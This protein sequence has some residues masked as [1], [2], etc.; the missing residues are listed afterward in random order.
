MNHI[1]HFVPGIASSNVPVVLLH[2]SGGDEHELFPL[3][4]DVAPGSPALGVRGTVAI[5]G[6]FAFFHRHP[7]RSI[8]ERDLD[9]RIPALREFI[10]AANLSKPPVAIGFSNG[11]IM[12]A[13]LL[14]THPTLFS[15]AVLFRP[16]SPFLED[17]PTRVE[18]VP[19]LII[20]GE[21]DSRRSPGDGARLEQRLSLAGAAVTHH[22][23][24][25][26][27]TITASDR[28]IARG[29]LAEQVTPA[30]FRAPPDRPGG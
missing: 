16:L 20:D 7:D 5:D 22:V 12:V 29:W 15:A 2:G 13:A 19:V 10:T 11:A 17:R 14:L 9:A 30:L 26:G 4:A 25:V 27:H 21:K 18:G 23:L 28:D 24:P 3:A 6:G 1:H 8:D